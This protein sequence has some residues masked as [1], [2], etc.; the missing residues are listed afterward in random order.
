MEFIIA[1]ECIEKKFKN[2]YVLNYKTDNNEDYF[3]I[4]YLYDK[5]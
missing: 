5:N 1:N 2:V 3:C 4:K